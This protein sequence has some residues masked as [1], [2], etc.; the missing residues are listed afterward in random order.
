MSAVF[1]GSSFPSNE[2]A[3]LAVRPELH[4]RAQ[5]GGLAGAVATQQHG[6]LA[7]GDLEVHAVEDVVSADVGVDGLQ[8]E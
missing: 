3:S 1:L 7:L 4:Q 5:G 8:F 2:D 6:D